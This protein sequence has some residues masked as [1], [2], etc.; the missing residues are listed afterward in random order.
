MKKDKGMKNYQMKECKGMWFE[1]A[2]QVK[3]TK[4]KATKKKLKNK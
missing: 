2:I 1:L 3:R 4:K